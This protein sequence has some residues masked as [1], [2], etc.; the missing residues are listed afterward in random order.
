MFYTGSVSHH[1]QAPDHLHSLVPK[2][3]SLCCI[4]GVKEAPL[5]GEN[6]WGPRKF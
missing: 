4:L 1:F 5:S 6:D 2:I 3:G